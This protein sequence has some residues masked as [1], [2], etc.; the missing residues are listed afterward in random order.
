MDPTTISSLA[1]NPWITLGGSVIGLL[2]LVLAAVFYAKAK[3]ER[4]PCYEYSNK[5]LIEGVDKTLDGLQLH[6]RGQPQ[7]RITVTK[8]VFW[9]EGRETIDK[10]NLVIADPIRIICPINIDVLNIQITNF[11][12]STNAI[13]LGLPSNSDEYQSYPIEFE[14]LDYREYFVIQIVHNG[15]DSQS[16]CITGKIKG[17]SKFLRFS[18][19]TGIS[20][21]LK[22]IPFVPQQLERMLTDRLIMKYAGTTAYLGYAGVGVWALTHGMNDWYVWAGTAFS[23]FGA[24]FMYFAH[25]RIAPVKI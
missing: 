22:S 5:T 21:K 4:I 9:N 12:S 1:S 8:I 25:R 14:Y 2:G 6:Y 13:K 24:L 3:K 7:S 19:L 15:D 17:V 23:V 10:N 20:Q 11:S 16:F 18:A